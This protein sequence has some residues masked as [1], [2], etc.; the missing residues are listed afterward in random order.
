M[1]QHSISGAATYAHKSEEKCWEACEVQGSTVCLTSAAQG[2]L[3]SCVQFPF[4]LKIAP[5]PLLFVHLPSFYFPGKMR[6]T[7][8]SWAS[9]LTVC[10]G[11][12][13]VTA[14]VLLLSSALLAG[15]ACQLHQKLQLVFVKE[16][17]ALMAL[18]CS[19]ANACCF[20][21]DVPDD[22]TVG[23]RVEFVW[24]STSF[25]RMRAALKQL[26]QDRTSISGYLYHTLLG[27]ELF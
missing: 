23:F 5:S 14:S 17:R 24:K 21:Q 3:G 10:G 18:P 4:G 7:N 2:V 13:A 19:F 6:L 20:P 11:P 22:C 16:S 15:C 25:D 1:R 26:D 8:A 9:E 27:E 12:A